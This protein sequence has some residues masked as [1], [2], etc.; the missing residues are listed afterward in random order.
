MPA[1]DEPFELGPHGGLYVTPGH[2]PA[3][4]MR[5]AV[6]AAIETVGGDGAEDVPEARL[7]HVWA[8]W[9]TPAEDWLDFVAAGTPGAEPYTALYLD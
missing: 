1:L 2:H 5:A 3:P 6:T 7:E 4:A 9:R 8:R